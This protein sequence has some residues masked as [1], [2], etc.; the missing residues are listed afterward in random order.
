[1]QYL[2]PKGEDIGNR[3]QKGRGHSV[4][5]STADGSRQGVDQPDTTE[6]ILEEVFADPHSK[7]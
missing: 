5:A 2:R 4:K 1:M 7:N 3:T 6:N